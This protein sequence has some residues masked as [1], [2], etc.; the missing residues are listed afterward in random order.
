MDNNKNFDN[1]C[2]FVDIKVDNE[3]KLINKDLLEILQQNY[4][5]DELDD[6]LKGFNKEKKTTFRINLLKSSF[7]K[8]EN[9]LKINKIK[10]ERCKHIEFAYFIDSIDFD[11]LKQTDIYKNGEIYVQN[12]SSMLP[13][14]CL[15]SKSGQDILDMCSAPGGKTSLICMLN[16]NKSHIIA[17]EI[18]KQRFERLKYNLNNL[19]CKNVNFMQI[20]ALQLDDFY[21]FDRILLDAP[22]SGSGTIT[23][24]D[25]NSQL[26]FSKNL[27]NNCIKTQS[28]LLKKAIGLL[29]KGETMIY[30]TCSIL[31]QE[32]EDI[33]SNI[34]H[35]KKVETQKIDFIENCLK[36]NLLSTNLKNTYCI[37]PCE[38]YEGFFI[39]KLVKL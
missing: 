8:V 3:T 32:N 1:K 38:L 5:Q 7:E 10:Y 34:L 21:R 22:C 26:N 14:L 31:R 4:S 2:K 11:K 9:E 36:D 16:E 30:S 12:L 18:N 28:Q 33:I 35:T 29:K 37:K 15:D 19:G 27:V 17:C 20:N 39:C 25:I 6:I 24:N 23:L 13:S